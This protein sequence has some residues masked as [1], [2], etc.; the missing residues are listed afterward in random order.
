LPELLQ[1]DRRNLD[2]RV[3]KE[4]QVGVNADVKVKRHEK[5]RKHRTASK[6]KIQA[7]IREK[8]TAIQISTSRRKLADSN[9]HE[10]IYER[11]SFLSQPGT[12]LGERSRASGRRLKNELSTFRSVQ[13]PANLH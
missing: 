9:N 8:G 4:L 12:S 2:I 6:R 3:R 10:L 1:A 7:L 11:S 13:L 5:R